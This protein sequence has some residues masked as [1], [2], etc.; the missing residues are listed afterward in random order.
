MRI[1]IFF[2]T[3]LITIPKSYFVWSVTE[4]VGGYFCVANDN[5]LSKE[6]GTS[7]D[8]TI[9]QN[10]PQISAGREQILVGNTPNG[11]R[12]ALLKFATKS[13]ESFPRDA[14]IVCAEIRLYAVV[15]N[16]DRGKIPVPSTRLHQVTSD[17]T[18]TGNTELASINGGF[19]NK[20]DTTWTYSK[21]PYVKW[22]CLGGDFNPVVLS[23]ETL[24]DDLHWFGDT[25]E[26]T[27][28]AQNGSMAVHQIT[29]L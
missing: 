21:Y 26:M 29:V 13:F 24:A 28:L 22:K 12:R 25:P 7:D 16:E 15:A 27:Q 11:Q 10:Q 4:T 6:F 14:K 2:V 9:F 17:W 23:T 1:K 18:T 19:V 5:V 3:L 20:G 8:A